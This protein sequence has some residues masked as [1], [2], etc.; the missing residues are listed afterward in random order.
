MRQAVAMLAT[1]ELDPTPLYTHRLPL[2]ELGA[3]MDLVR[4]RPDGFMKAL[5]TTGYRQ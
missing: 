2:E 1:G 5:V 3:A 4:Q